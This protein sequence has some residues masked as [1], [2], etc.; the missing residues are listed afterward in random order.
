MPVVPAL[1]DR[2]QLGLQLYTL[3]HSV[4]PLVALLPR[5]AACGYR[6]VEL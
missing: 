4:E 2:P 6:G 1:D 5:L 3:R